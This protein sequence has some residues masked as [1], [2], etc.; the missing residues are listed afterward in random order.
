[1]KNNVVSDSFIRKNKIILKLILIS[2]IFGAYLII[3]G[4]SISVGSIGAFVA[5]VF[6]GVVLAL[7]V[8]PIAFLLTRNNLK[9]QDWWLISGLVISILATL[10]KI[11]VIS[12]S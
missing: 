4:G 3:L 7:P 11:I 1:M 2:A 5:Y 12:F 9:S 6:G 10:S 8:Y